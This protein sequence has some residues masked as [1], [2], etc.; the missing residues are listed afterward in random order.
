[1]NASRDVRPGGVLGH[2]LLVGVF[3]LAVFL[4]HTV[5]HADGSPVH[6]MSPASPSAGHPFEERTSYGSVQLSAQHDGSS[7]LT[8]PFGGTDMASLCVGMISAF[9]G[10]SLLRPAFTRHAGWSPANGSSFAERLRSASLS[11]EPNPARSRL[12]VLRV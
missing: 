12:P 3:A 7:A 1:M 9:A 11:R 4:M 6:G 8:S 10:A 2:L 5:G